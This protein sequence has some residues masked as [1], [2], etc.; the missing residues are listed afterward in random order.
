MIKMTIFLFL[1]KIK[2]YTQF[3]ES[4]ATLISWS[5]SSIILEILEAS[6]K[7]LPASNL[8]IPS[9]VL[10]ASR[11]WRFAVKADVDD[12]EIAV[13][14][15]AAEN[16]MMMLLCLNSLC[17]LWNNIRRSLGFYATAKSFERGNGSDLCEWR[18]CSLADDR[19]PVR[20]WCLPVVKT[21][22]R[23][24]P[25]RS[26]LQQSNENPR[27]LLEETMTNACDVNL[28]VRA[29]YSIIFCK[30]TTDARKTLLPD[31]NGIRTNKNQRR[32]QDDNR[33][34]AWK[35][36]ASCSPSNF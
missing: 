23:N 28:C 4:S 16:F 33:Q 7:K 13:A 22:C 10:A 15:R 8:A 3:T 9:C 6:S 25:E 20:N 14:T 19:D 26:Q 21:F 18:W 27:I 2:R 36:S 32:A 34:G 5:I 24:S 1:L 17:V 12:T 11:F 29:T 31:G 35:H 30:M